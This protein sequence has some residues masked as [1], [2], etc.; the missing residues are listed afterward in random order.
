MPPAAGFAPPRTRS[1]TL[2]PF[3]T[4][5]S[6]CSSIS[7]FTRSSRRLGQ[8]DRA[9]LPGVLRE[10]VGLVHDDHR[11]GDRYVHPVQ[12]VVADEG[13][14]EIGVWG[15]DHRGLGK[16][17]LGQLVRAQ[18]LLIAV[19]D[20][21]LHGGQVLVAVVLDV[22]EL[23][24]QDR[25]VEPTSALGFFSR[26]RALR[27]AHSL[28]SSSGE[29]ERSSG[30]RL[31]QGAGALPSLQADPEHRPQVVDLTELEHDLALLG[32]RPGEIDDLLALAPAPTAASRLRAHTVLPVPVPD[33]TARWA[34]TSR[35]R[36][37]H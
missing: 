11:V 36:I 10:V 7:F 27:S 2:T 8:R 32:V 37:W 9:D 18:A 6:P 28:E 12:E 14:E 3:S 26:E 22:L 31:D 23:S 17:V 4:S 25:L 34:R 21:L 16:K 29:P 24:G 20:E 19:G 15:G 5:G 1:S 33:S 30:S 35:W 13:H